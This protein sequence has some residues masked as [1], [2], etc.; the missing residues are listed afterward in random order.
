MSQPEPTAWTVTEEPPPESP[1]DGHEHDDEAAH[2]HE[3][4]SDG[5]EG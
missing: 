3:E 2:E 5:R 4:E 1:E